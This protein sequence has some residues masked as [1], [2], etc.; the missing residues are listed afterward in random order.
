MTKRDFEAMRKRLWD[1]AWRG[2]DHFR[3]AAFVRREVDRAVRA[4]RR[5]VQAAAVEASQRARV[6]EIRWQG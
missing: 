2:D 1:G 4:E 6:R 5:R 3:I